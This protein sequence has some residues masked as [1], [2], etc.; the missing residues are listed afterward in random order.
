MDDRDQARM[1]ELRDARWGEDEARWVLELA[2]KDGLSLARLAADHGL[3]PKRLCWWRV[4]LERRSGR[5][6]KKPGPFVPVR[7]VTDDPRENVVVDTATESGVTV[8]TATGRRVHLARGFD[9]AT[10]AQTLRVLDARC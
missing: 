1:R 2:A 7:V 6:P 9:P 4:R 5:E 8:E 10:L 3:S